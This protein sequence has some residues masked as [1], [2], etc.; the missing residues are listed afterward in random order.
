MSSTVRIFH[1][2]S[3]VTLWP[4][5]NIFVPRLRNRM[6]QA[7]CHYYVSA[8]MICA[9]AILVTGR[10]STVNFPVNLCK[11]GKDVSTVGRIVHLHLTCVIHI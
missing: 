1:Q 9:P 6:R 11:F 3:L 4:L 7:Y 5:I 8:V 10:T 2:A